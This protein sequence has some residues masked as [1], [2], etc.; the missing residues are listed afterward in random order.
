M[1]VR[2]LL[3]LYTTNLNYWV[4]LPNYTRRSF[5]QNKTTNSTFLWSQYLTYKLLSTPLLR[6]YWGI[7]LQPAPLLLQIHSSSFATF[8]PTHQPTAVVYIRRKWAHTVVSQLLPYANAVARSFVEVGLMSANYRPR[9]LK[10]KTFRSSVFAPYLPIALT[11]K[12]VSFLLNHRIYFAAFKDITLFCS[13]FDLFFVKWYFLRFRPTQFP[14]LIVFNPA[15][16]FFTVFTT[17][18]LLDFKLLISLFKLGLTKLTIYRHKFF[19]SFIFKYILNHFA[20]V[21]SKFGVK[22]LLIS[23]KG[24]VGVSGSSR[25][26]RLMLNLNQTSFFNMSYRVKYESISINTTSGAVGLRLWMFYTK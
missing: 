1:W 18:K 13:Q 8:A 25:K 7:A 17:F 20:P 26:R 11:I 16:F 6:L 24:K 2:F 9:L 23:V 22:G 19:I 10:N 14:L 21:F 12:T 15:E 3:L 5:L 4:R